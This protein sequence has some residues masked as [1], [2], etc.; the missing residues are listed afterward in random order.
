MFGYF[1]IDQFHS[2][3]HRYEE[4]ENA[5]MSANPTIN[6][7]EP[8]PESKEVSSSK[9]QP[10]RPVPRPGDCPRNPRQGGL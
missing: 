4:K 3:R 7:A 5:Y 2:I 9:P 10:A 8:R 6:G 1:P